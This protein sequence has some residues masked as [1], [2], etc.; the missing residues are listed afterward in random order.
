MP[1]ACR[2]FSVN[3]YCLRK[4]WFRT[5]SVD[6][7]EGDI[8][9]ITSRVKSYCYQDLFQK[10][11]EV[12]LYRRVEEG[13]L[14]LHH[15][16]SKAQ[17]HLIANFIQTAADT[18][19]RQSLFHS[20]LFR[21]HVIGDTTLPDPG[22]TPYY[23]E[24]FFKVIRDV[25][26]NSPLNPADMKVKDWYIYLLE[27]NVTKRETGQGGSCE[28]VPCKVE[29]RRP[30]GCWTECYRIIRFKGLNPDSKSFLFK[31]VHTLL[32]SKER[33]HYLTT[34]TSPQ[35]WCGG[36][37]DETYVH[38]FYQCPKNREAGQALLKC[39]Q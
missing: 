28:L 36:G 14:G 13:G 2:P 21:Y 37:A 6:L 20:W 10:P 24:K 3:T 35:C 25:N 9:A 17:A 39:V 32:P 34:K 22:Y 30:E 38:L 5:S 16:Q 23:D 27:K 26:E 12:L 15:V 7:R 11:S 19:F 1:I 31:L 8:K 18:R 29:E 33:L 4:V